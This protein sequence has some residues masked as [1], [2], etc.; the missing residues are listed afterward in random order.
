MNL[1]W[2]ALGIFLL[3]YLIN[4]FYITVLYHRA[5]THGAITL[6]PWVM[7]ILGSTGVWLTGLEP[8]AWACMHRLHHLH[9]DQ[10]EDPHSPKIKGIWSVWYSQYSS[11]RKIVEGLKN[12]QNNYVELV[13]DIPFELSFISRRLDL[14]WLPYVLHIL[15]A[16][17]IVA[18]SD[19]WLLAWAYYLGIMGHPLQGWMV[20]A[21]AHRYGS[22]RFNTQDDSRNNW[23][24]ALFV[25]GEGF[26]NNHHAHPSRAN[27]SFRRYEIDLGYLM[28]VLAE[29]IGFVTIRKS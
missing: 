28:C 6:K 18:L 16:L 29:K 5:L 11:Y 14:S 8:K 24:V 27:F 2:T 26:Q 20:N 9:S 7:Q 13:K 3:T 12:K 17:A 10:T 22:R 19:S 4:I 23:W 25:F 15:V 1:F 21:L